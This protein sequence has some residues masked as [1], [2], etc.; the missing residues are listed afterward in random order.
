[1]FS[2]CVRFLTGRVIAKQFMRPGEVEWPIHPARL[3]M[4]LA[5]THYET[6]NDPLHEVALEDE[7]VDAIEREMLQWL[8]SLA[9]PVITNPTISARRVVTVF[10]PVNDRSSDPARRTKQPRQFPS[11]YVGDQILRF[12]WPD[13]LPDRFH[14][15]L[16]RLL[17]SV[18]RVG[19]SSSLVQCWLD[20]DRESTRQTGQE[21]WRPTQH[22]SGGVTTRLRTTS[23]GTLAMLDRAMNLQAVDEYANL[24]LVARDGESPKIR[25]SA[26]SKLSQSFPNGLPRSQPPYISTTAIYEKE[27]ATQPQVLLRTCF[28]PIL[29][30]L[31]RIEGAAL[32]LQHTLDVCRMLRNAILNYGGKSAPEWLTG[33]DSDGRA[34]KQPHLAIVPLANVGQHASTRPDGSGF[35]EHADGH[36]MGLGLVLPADL[37]PQS[38]GDTLGLFLSDAFGEPRSHTLTL[39]AKGVWNVERETRSRAPKGLTPETWS[40]ASRKWATVT[41]IVLDRHP[42]QDPRKN[43]SGWRDEVAQLVSRSCTHIGLPHPSVVRVEKHGFLKGVPSSQPRRTG[44]PLMNHS[45]GKTQRL[46]THALLEFE[47]PVQGP[48]LLGAGRFR[49]YGFCKPIDHRNTDS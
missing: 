11:G 12:T 15:A 1:M 20:L 22:S 36:L 7:A 33:H 43:L 40:R 2:I 9:P 44:F 35:Q 21:Q 41:P 34:T 31:T 4:A 28:D 37:N 47:H 23:P 32:G 17:S 45:D 8:E 6:A 49:G 18:V 48:V 25:K 27:E 26:K 16:N 3:F 46:Q 14:D 19:H 42:K 29:I 13:E 5:A 38:I 39:G 10:V 24:T 30:P